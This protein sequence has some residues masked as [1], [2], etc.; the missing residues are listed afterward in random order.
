MRG[1]ETTSNNELLARQTHLF[2]LRALKLHSDFE[3]SEQRNKLLQRDLS[4]AESIAKGLKIKND[5]CVRE[6]EKMTSEVRVQNEALER[7]NEKTKTLESNRDALELV[8]KETQSELYLV[9]EETERRIRQLTMEQ[10]TSESR[11]AER[12]ERALDDAAVAFSGERRDAD[13]EM[14]R[15]IERRLEVENEREKCLNALEEKERKWEKE[16]RER[17]AKEGKLTRE[18]EQLTSENE[19][20]KDQIKSLEEECRKANAAVRERSADMALAVKKL[21]VELKQQRLET[22]K[23]MAKRV[24]AL[25]VAFGNAIEDVKEEARASLSRKDEEIARVLAKE[26]EANTRMASVEKHCLKVRDAL[27][28]LANE[29]ESLEEERD[30]LRRAL[31]R[32]GEMNAQL[33]KRAMDNAS[34]TGGGE[35]LAKQ[36]QKR[37]AFTKIPSNVHRHHQYNKGPK[38]LAETLAKELEQLKSAHEESIEALTTSEN[39]KDLEKMVERIDEISRKIAAKATQVSLALKSSS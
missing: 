6:I 9:K 27:L 17:D 5:E 15:H 10:S 11:R 39:G 25:R 4:K 19:K 29:K 23:G 20:R 26:S 16:R 8:V 28:E 36:Q 21:N 30:E 18:N 22:E 7:T 3:R 1:E 35:G 24:E 34:A 38:Q 37:A 13:D 31:Q 14:R 12:A 32:A 33:T 2:K